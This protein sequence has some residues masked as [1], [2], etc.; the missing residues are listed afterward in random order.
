VIVV[1]GVVNVETSVPVEGFP[2]GYVPVRYPRWEIGTRVAGVGYGVAAG[3]SALGSRVRLATFLAD[4]P[5]GH[6]V[7]AALTECGLWGD[8]VVTSSATPRA[9]VLFDHQGQRM[10]STDL[11]DLPE[12]DYPAGRFA[13][14][15]EGAR[16]A[17]VTNIGFARPLLDV[18]RQAGVPIAAD[19]QAISDLDDGY[20]ADWMAAADIVFCSHE[21]LPVPPE[22]WAG[23]VIDRY[24]CKIVV[25]GL[26][27]EGALLALE[28]QPPRRVPAVAP[29]G[30]RNTVGAGDA[31]SAGF[32]HAYMATGDAHTAIE[33]AVVFA[34]YK[35]GAPGGEDGYCSDEELHELTQAA[36]AG[37]GSPSSP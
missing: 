14:A 10:V 3:L 19:V 17:V 35:I 36:F 7:R 20:N 31:L 34:G 29:R 26:G 12:A 11:R 21:R 4:D 23:A 6:A 5:L 13:A 28:G 33:H 16:L 24:G 2:L 27:A 8:A 22:E 9:V 18:A 25:V 30:V 15:L 32:L 1:A 37:T